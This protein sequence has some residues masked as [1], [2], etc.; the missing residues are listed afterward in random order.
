VEFSLVHGGYRDLEGRVV[1]QSGYLLDE[2]G[3]V[4]D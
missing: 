3:N 1:N 4:V 2:D